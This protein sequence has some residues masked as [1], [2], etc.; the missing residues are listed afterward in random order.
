MQTLSREQALERL[1]SLESEAAQLKKILDAEIV[2]DCLI[3]TPEKGQ[4]FYYMSESENGKLGVSETTRTNGAHA[5]M[6]HV[7]Q[8]AEK[9]IAAWETLIMLRKQPGSEPTEDKKFQWMIEYDIEA[10]KPVV[11]RRFVLNSKVT[12]ISPAYASEDAAN[13]AI[14]AVGAGKIVGMFKTLHGIQ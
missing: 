10:N 13:K 4:T 11:I 14:R 2:Y 3:P 6:F 5:N 8:A 1:V 12:R 7:K 9:H